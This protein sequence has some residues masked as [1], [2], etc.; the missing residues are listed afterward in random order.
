VDHGR[1]LRCYLRDP[2]GHLIEVGQATGILEG[3]TA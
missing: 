1:E 3:R 2:D